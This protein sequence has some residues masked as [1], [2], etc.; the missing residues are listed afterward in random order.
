[1]NVE[2]PIAKER[3]SDAVTVG[4]EAHVSPAYARAKPERLW[5]KVWLQ[6]RRLEDVPEFRNF[7]T[8]KILDDSAI[9]VR[10]TPDELH[11]FYNVCPHRGRRLIDRPAVEKEQ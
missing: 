11:T 1:V 4:P 6:A 5:R 10:T 2:T 3:L 7:I 8:H 9:I